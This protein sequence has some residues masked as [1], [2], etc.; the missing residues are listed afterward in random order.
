MRVPFC[1]N[2][3]GRFGHE[4]QELAANLPQKRKLLVDSKDESAK[5]RNR[6]LGSARRGLPEEQVEAAA[7]VEKLQLQ[8]NY[9]LFF[10]FC[11]SI[12]AFK[13]LPREKAT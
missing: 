4:A 12:S 2:G 10:C 9:V 5:K 3:F 6:S 11:C 1:G 8:F 13:V 7:K